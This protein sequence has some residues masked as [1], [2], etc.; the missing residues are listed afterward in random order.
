MSTTRTIDGSGLSDEWFQTVRSD[1]FISH[2]HNDANLAF[3]LAGWLKTQFDLNIFM[4]KSIWG[5]ADAL[6]RVMDDV[7]CWQPRRNTYHYKKRNLTTSHVHAVLSTAIY[8]AID[9]PEVVF[10]LNTRE[11]IPKMDDT[12]REDSEY[13]L[14]PWIYQELMTT[15]LLRK[16]DWPGYRKSI[17]LEHTQYI[18]ESA[19]LKL[20]VAYKTP[21]CELTVL[22]KNCCVFRRTNIKKAIF[23]Y[24]ER[25]SQIFRIIS[26]RHCI[27]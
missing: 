8:F 17:G 3:A 6:L 14:S 18:K 25:F 4:D 23:F 24:V 20:K 21:L 26:L 9:K 1:V 10:F 7:F 19:D 27:W 15:K 13:T 11:S 12:R 16:T 22:D 2:S 5:S